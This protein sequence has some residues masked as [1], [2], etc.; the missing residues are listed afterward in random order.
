MTGEKTANMPLIT[1][2]LLIFMAAVLLGLMVSFARQVTVSHRQGQELA[3]LK[4][5][6]DRANEELMRLQVYL[7]HVQSEHFLRLWGERT[8]GS[9]RGKSWSCPLEKRLHQRPQLTRPLRRL[10][11]KAQPVR[12]GGISSLARSEAV[13]P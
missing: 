4:G 8:V 7:Q 1:R 12:R 6:I 10:V 11:S 3:R 9:S 5:E 2:L 13:L